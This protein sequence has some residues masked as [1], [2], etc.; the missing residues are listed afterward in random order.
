[1]CY[2][3]LQ[4]KGCVKDFFDVVD[5]CWQKGDKVSKFIDEA[6]KFY[7]GDDNGGERIA[8]FFAE[9]GLDC[10]QERGE[11]VKRCVEEKN[12]IDEETVHEQLSGNPE[13]LTDAI[14]KLKVPQSDEICKK[15]TELHEC[16]SIGLKKCKDPTPEN[17]M[18]SMLRQVG[19]ALECK[20]AELQRSDSQTSSGAEQL[21]AIPLLA[22]GGIAALF[23][24]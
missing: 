9:G 23:A 8:I 1:M 14:N 24:F 10:V 21:I 2:L 16:A 17:L 15:I 6:V 13:D 11:E 3:R 12:G 5:E 18:T 19:K 4:V 7:C 22:L 20:V